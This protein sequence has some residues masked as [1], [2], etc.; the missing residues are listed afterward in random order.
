MKNFKKFGIIFTILMISA[1]CVN[2]CGTVTP[3][4]ETTEEEKKLL[5]LTQSIDT[6]KITVLDNPVI[7]AGETGASEG[8]S[9][10]EIGVENGYN[11]E[12][13]D[14]TYAESDGKFFYRADESLPLS[15]NYFLYSTA[16]GKRR[17]GPQEILVI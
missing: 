6:S 13:V 7:I 8:Y 12:I 11:I 9:L 14:N 1:L 2:G 10:I 4:E 16:P 3:E 15:D 17:N 5:Q